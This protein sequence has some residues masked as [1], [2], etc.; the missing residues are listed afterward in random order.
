M[1]ICTRFEVQEV[2]GRLRCTT[3]LVPGQAWLLVNTTKGIID[4]DADLVL[5]FHFRALY[6]DQYFPFCNPMRLISSLRLEELRLQ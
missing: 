2:S 4:L 3:L 6:V 5:S 1:V